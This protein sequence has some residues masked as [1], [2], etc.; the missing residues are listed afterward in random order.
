[1]DVVFLHGWLMGPDLWDP[2][3]AA[4][5][6]IADTHALAAPAH[7]TPLLSEGFDTAAWANLVM[8]E[9]DRRSVERAVFVGHSMGG[10]LTQQ[11]WRD[12]PQRVAGIGIVGQAARSA[13]PEEAEQFKDLGRRVATKWRETA[14]MLA[15]L[16]IGPGYLAANPAWLEHWID[17]L[18]RDYDLAGMVPLTAALAERPDY[19]PTTSRIDVPTV[20]VHG[21]DDA[22]IPLDMGRH[23]ASLIPTAELV[24]IRG[25]GHAPPMEEP[26]AV[27]VAVRALVD[28]VTK[29]R[30][31][32]PPSSN[33]TAAGQ[34]I[35]T[36][37]RPEESH[38]DDH[39]T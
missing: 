19:T 30:H 12:H 5:D 23:L 37:N 14:P 3:V 18:E 9:L 1:M 31:D 8:E 15:K 17:H 29:H 35:H 21:T 7:G 25:A 22:A 28:R 26:E 4:L 34:L 27:A 6:G 39:R 24:E 20:V 10:W 38:A 2:Q 16:L 13:T 36:T 11:I 32:R 33:R